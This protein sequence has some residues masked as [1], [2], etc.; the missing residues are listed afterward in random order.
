[1]NQFTENDLINNIIS[2]NNFAEIMLIYHDNIEQLWDYTI[3][4]FDDPM[5]QSINKEPPLAQT[6]KLEVVK[7]VSIFKSSFCLINNVVCKEM[8]RNSCADFEYKNCFDLDVNMMNMLIE[9]HDNRK[10]SKSNP[11]MTDLN[12]FCNDVTCFPYMLENAGKISDSYV[13]ECAIRTLLIYNKFK[14]SDLH[15]FSVDYQHEE[16]DFQDT[17]KSIDFMK[18]IS[19]GENEFDRILLLQKSIYALILK[20]TIISFHNKNGIKKKITELL[21]FVNKDLGIFLE[22]E[23]VF[24]YWFLKNRNDDRIK[25]FFK[26]IQTNA[27]NIVETI[28]GMSWDLFHLRFCTEIG[29]ANDIDDGAICMHY[30]VTK[31]KGL[32]RLANEHPIKYFIHKKGDILPTIVFEKPIYEVIKEID[33]IKNL[34]ENKTE[35]NENF[36]NGNIDQLIKFLENQLILGNTDIIL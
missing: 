34:S 10:N 18:G 25:E 8:M 5:T 20:T 12:L 36:K 4:I 2:A 31:D 32:A 16:Q 6:M 1:M 14:H 13:E 24:C 21:E 27:N 26:K 35:R 22:R 23:I 9:I 30:L 19:N 28:Q 15:S 7:V 11:I 17:K 29:M 3:L 33:I